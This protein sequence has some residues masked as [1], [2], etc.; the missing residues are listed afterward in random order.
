MKL[1]PAQQ[2]FVVKSYVEF[3]ENPTNGLV[4]D[5]RLQTDRQTV[6]GFTYD[7][8]FLLRE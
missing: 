6:V 8:L 7:T 5:A 2:P 4:A 3:H 1:W